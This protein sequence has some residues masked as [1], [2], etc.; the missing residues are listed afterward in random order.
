MQLSKLFSLATS[1]A[2]FHNPSSICTY[3]S[4]NSKYKMKKGS[5]EIV[6]WYCKEKSHH[7][8]DRCQR[9]RKE[10][11]K[12]NQ[13]RLD[14]GGPGPKLDD[15]DKAIIAFRFKSE[16]K[17]NKVISAWQTVYVDSV[18]TMHMFLW[19]IPYCPFTRPRAVDC[20]LQ[21]VVRFWK[22]RAKEHLKFF[23]PGNSTSPVRLRYICSEGRLQPGFRR[24]S[25][26]RWTHCSVH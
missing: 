1:L 3:C 20:L 25:V 24:W 7:L 10:A 21:L 17:Q 26:G 4:L 8:V 19:T 6:Y 23:F 13:S 22:G 15:T 14:S 16:R 12:K 11:D 9:K 18:S 5:N 2:D